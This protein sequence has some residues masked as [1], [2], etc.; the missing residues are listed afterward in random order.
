MRTCR[1]GR[2]S[3]PV[4]RVAR[5]AGQFRRGWD[6]PGHPRRGRAQPAPAAIAL[7]RG[8]RGED[9]ARTWWLAALAAMRGDAGT[10]R[11]SAPGQGNSS[12]RRSCWHHGEAARGPGPARRR[13]GGR[14]RLAGADLGR[15]WTDAMRAEAAVLAG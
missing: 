7:V 14:L 11:P 10:K 5:S 4:D 9:K 13:A 1:A 12:R 2:A 3:G 15:R 6:A 8:L